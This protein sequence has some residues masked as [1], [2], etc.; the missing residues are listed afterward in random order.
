MIW[1]FASGA[2]VVAFFACYVIYQENLSRIRFP[3]DQHEHG[4]FGR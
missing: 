4:P 3:D 1:A 2:C